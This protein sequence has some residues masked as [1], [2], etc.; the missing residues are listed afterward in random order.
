MD[1]MCIFRKLIVVFE[2]MGTMFKIL[3][4]SRMIHLHSIKIH[5]ELFLKQCPYGTWNYTKYFR[6]ENAIRVKTSFLCET[7]ASP[8]RNVLPV[9]GDA[10]LPW[11]RAVRDVGIDELDLVDDA[12]HRGLQVERVEMHPR[13]ALRQQLPTPA[14]D[15]GM[16]RMLRKIKK[17]ASNKIRLS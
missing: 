16:Y 8:T 3:G 14:H 12:L 13:N 9:D 15:D 17:S 7:R 6:K 5:L 4:A 11:Q 1:N 10:G 2:L